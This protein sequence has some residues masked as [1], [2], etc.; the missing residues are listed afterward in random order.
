MLNSSDGGEQLFYYDCFYDPK[1]K[2]FFSNILRD[3]IIICHCDE[4]SD[5]SVFPGQVHR[6]SFCGWLAAKMVILLPYCRSLKN[7]ALFSLIF[8]FS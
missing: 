7:S 5:H 1:T 3:F 8:I 4:D 2:A 6:V